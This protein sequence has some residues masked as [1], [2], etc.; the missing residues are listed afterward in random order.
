MNFQQILQTLP[1][2]EGIQQIDIIN[3]QTEIVHT[4]PAIIG[5]LG[6]LR[7]YHA[8][9][10]KYNGELD[11]NSAQQGLEWFAEHY[12]DALENPGKH[13]NIDLLLS[14][15]TNDKHWKIKVLK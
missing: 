13:P 6:S 9:A 12:Q 10:Q 5:K 14:V 15:I 11:K 4:I 7:V 1:S 8:L 2:I 3:S